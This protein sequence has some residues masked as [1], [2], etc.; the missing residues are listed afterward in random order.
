M[1]NEYECIL[2]EFIEAGDCNKDNVPEE[3]GLKELD[4]NDELVELVPEAYLDSKTPTE[5]EI[6]NN[7][8]KQMRELISFMI[9]S[10]K[11]DYVN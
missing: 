4:L 3:F 5:E 2:K 7:I 1:F 9:R 6:Q 8:D 10:G 11:E